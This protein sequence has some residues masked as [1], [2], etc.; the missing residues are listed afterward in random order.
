MSN[1]K[2]ITNKRK[3]RA[4]KPVLQKSI[5]MKLFPIL[6]LILIFIFIN[7]ITSSLALSETL[8]TR[9]STSVKLPKQKTSGKK[10]LEELIHARRSKRRYSSG[11]LTI[12][13]ISQILWAAQGITSNNGRYRSTPS[14]GALYPI[15]TYIN[16]SNVKQL[17]SGLYKYEPQNHNLK[18]INSKDLKKKIHRFALKQ[19]SVLGAQAIIIISSTPNKTKIKYGS[20]TMKY[21]FIEAGCIAQNIYLQSEALGLGTVLIGAFNQERIKREFKLSENEVP[22]YIMPIGKKQMKSHNY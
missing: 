2:Q 14:A 5:L 1:I 17:A 16:I 4:E 3:S 21:I 12:E 10:S 15:E 22:I 13:Q 8:K 20:K 19:S 9:A 6:L 7:L 11:P 18:I